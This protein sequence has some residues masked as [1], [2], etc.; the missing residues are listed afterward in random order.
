MRKSAG[1]APL[2]GQLLFSEEGQGTV[3][4]DCVLAREGSN[5]PGLPVTLEAQFPDLARAAAA[6]EL[7]DRWADS[8][9]TVQVRV[10]EGPKGPE[11]EIASGSSRLVLEPED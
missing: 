7:L 11:V 3:I 9:A 2:V 5:G 8:E 4:L 10:N 6:L 1:T